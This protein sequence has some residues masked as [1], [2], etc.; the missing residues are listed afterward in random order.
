MTATP[1]RG[2]ATAHVLAQKITVLRIE[3][4]EP[5]PSNVRE[6]LGDLGDLSRSI[7]QQGI[8]QP[9]IAQP[10]PDQPGMYRLL[11]GHRRYAAA[12]LAGLDA[13]PVII[14]H[15]VTDSGALELMLVENCQ[16]QELNAM[17]RAE[18]L[19]ALI[20]RGYTQH[21]IAQKT[22][23]S[24]SW[25][26]YYLTLLDLD[27]DAREKVRTGELAV[28]TAINAVR[29]TRKKTRRK[30]GSTAT[31][32]WEPDHLT[33][34][35]PLARTARRLCDARDHTMRRRIGD[36]ACGQCWETA[37]RLDERTVMGAVTNTKGDTT[38]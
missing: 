7:R 17:E 35:H 10:S 14:R 13:V 28:T 3:K 9:L 33:D 5:H 24:Q 2:D 12:L 31:Y 26:G 1:A 34:R 23:M 29:K 30:K 22:G 27:E 36:T 15:G 20:N 6:D 19:G 8:L 16:R 37:I 11:A 25:V 4:I 21:Q 38:K 32:A 18:A